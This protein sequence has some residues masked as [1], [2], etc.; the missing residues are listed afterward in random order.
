MFLTP[1]WTARTHDELADQ[2]K[3]CAVT[4]AR[5]FHDHLHKDA[6]AS[7]GRRLRLGAHIL[8]DVPELH[9]RCVRFGQQSSDHLTK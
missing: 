2:I 3:I 5:G 7:R 8:K 6:A 9:T 1:G 4:D